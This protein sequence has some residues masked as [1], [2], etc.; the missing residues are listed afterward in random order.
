M[1]LGRYV[2]AAALLLTLV[3]GS[4]WAVG[5]EDFDPSSW[6]LQG[7]AKFTVDGNK[8]LSFPDALTVR[9][10]VGTFEVPEVDENGNPVLDDQGRQKTVIV[11]VRQLS[12]GLPRITLLPDPSC[13]AASL[14][15]RNNKSCVDFAVATRPGN[16]VELTLNDADVTR[17]IFDIA[18]TRMLQLGLGTVDLQAELVSSSAKGA[19]IKGGTILSLPIR[20]EANLSAASLGPNPVHIV[21][22]AKK[23]KGRRF[24]N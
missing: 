15:L 5:D 17:A 9:L 20:W 12:F 23:L 24:N 6:R 1:V 4:A 13:V 7:L 18:F 2:T 8:K 21:I 16:E 11:P 22:E 3:G 10:E 14:F 19:L